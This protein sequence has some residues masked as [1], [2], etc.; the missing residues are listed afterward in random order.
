MHRVKSFIQKFFKT[1][2]QNFF[3][4]FSQNLFSKVFYKKN[5][6]C[7]YLYRQGQ[8]SAVPEWVELSNGCLCCSVK[9]QFL[10]ALEQLV[11]GQYSYDCVL[12]ETTGNIITF[13]IS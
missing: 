4:N 10:Q 3:R 2:F 13:H 5:N 12:V 1:F 7:F 11:G 9:G 6:F 8:Q